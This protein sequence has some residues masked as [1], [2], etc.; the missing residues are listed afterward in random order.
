MK[1]NRHRKS[2]SELGSVFSEAA[3][4]LPVLL[5]VTMGVSQ[6]GRSLGNLVTVQQ[7]V[8]TSA[9]AASLSG[10]TPADD[11]QTRLTQLKSLVSSKFLSPDFLPSENPAS[12]DSQARTISMT[13]RA[14]LVELPLSLGKP[15]ASQS[16]FGPIMSPRD[17]QSAGNLANFENPKLE[18]GCDGSPGG[19]ASSCLG[20]V[21]SDS[22]IIADGVVLSVG[23]GGCDP[24]RVYCESA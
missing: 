6:L 8:Y 7:M 24:R 20:Q 1:F 15:S 16:I 5:M 23:G 4:V 12:S 17:T 18:Y 9:L 10:G 11:A 21:D 13:V 22:T 19:S 3:I 14:R 2:S